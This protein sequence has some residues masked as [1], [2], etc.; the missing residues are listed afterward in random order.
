[1]ESVANKARNFIQRNSW[2][3]YPRAKVKEEERKIIGT[4]LVFKKEIKAEGSKVPDI[5]SV[6]R[7]KTRGVTLG[8]QQIS[9][10]Y[11]TESHNPVAND[12]SVRMMI[13]ITLSTSLTLK[14]RVCT[15]S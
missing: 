3:K 14:Q 5:Y 11:Y 2:S 8:Y 12:T 15:E 10:I 6:H 1:M 7:Y 9:G 4:K 13:G